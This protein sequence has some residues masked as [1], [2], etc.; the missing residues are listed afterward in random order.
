MSSPSISASAIEQMLAQTEK[1]ESYFQLVWRRFRRSKISI[2]GAFIVLVLML[3]SA[4]ADFFSPNPID[5]DNLKDAFIPPNQIHFVDTEGNFSFRPF[6]YGIASTMDPKTFQVKF[7]EDTKKKYPIQF[8][9][10]TWS[11]KMLWH[12]SDQPASVWRGGPRPPVYAGH[13]QA[14]SRFVGQGLPGRAC[15]AVHE[16]VWHR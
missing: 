14:G 11:Y 2:I 3:L 12:I 16:P 4:F 6:V 13:R 7:V 1:N 15:L 9:V 8:F 10:R 5:G